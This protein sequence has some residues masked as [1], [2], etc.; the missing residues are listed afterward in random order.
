MMKKKRKEVW[1]TIPGFPDYNLVSNRGRVRHLGYWVEYERRGTLI[2][3]FQKGRVIKLFIDINGYCSVMIKGKTYHVAHLV[4]LASGKSR[5]EGHECDH[6]NWNPSDNRPSNLRW[7]TATENQR[8]RRN[9]VLN[10]QMVAHMRHLH[11]L[12]YR[13]CEI[14]EIIGFDR[15]SMHVYQVVRDESWKDIEPCDHSDKFGVPK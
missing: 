11:S 7:V 4:L 3:R 14:N 8:H 9:N 2:R 13:P 10:P 5:P 12:D 15:N 1:R 6:I